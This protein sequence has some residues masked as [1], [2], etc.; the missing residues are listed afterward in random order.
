MNN[1]C[2]KPICGAPLK[3]DEHLRCFNGHIQ[4]SKL[5]D[6]YKDTYKKTEAFKRLSG[7]GDG[8]K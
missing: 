5:F 3:D 2:F 1:I 7:D 4:N 8:K 6:R